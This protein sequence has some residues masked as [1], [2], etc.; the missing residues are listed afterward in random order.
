M[1]IVGNGVE[2]LR[3]FPW[4]GRELVYCDPP[5]LMSTRSGRRL[6]AHEMD[7]AGHREL[8]SLI[9]TIPAAVMISGYPSKLYGSALAKWNV[10]EFEAMTRGG[11]QRTE[12][13]WF[14]FPTPIAL[15]DYRYLGR[16]FRERE[17]I[18]RKR[19]RWVA[20]LER[21]PILERQ[22]LL[23]AIAETAGFDDGGLRAC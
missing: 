20:R 21:M 12:R 19:K 14:N 7:D 1:F 3:E 13:V 15:H 5:Y 8:V 23:S 17:R 2:V 11:T 22:S 10:M 4:T 16:D 9:Q 6:Y 18:G